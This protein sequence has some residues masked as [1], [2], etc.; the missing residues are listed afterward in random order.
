MSLQLEG[1]SIEIIDAHTHMGGRKPREGRTHFNSFSGDDMVK[2]MDKANVDA[3]VSF[4]MGVM[5]HGKRLQLSK[6]SDRRR[7]GETSRPHPRVL[8]H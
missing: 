6:R 5:E 4:P 3:T 1:E 7:H 8:P 2:S